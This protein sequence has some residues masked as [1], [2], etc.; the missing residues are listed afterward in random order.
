MSEFNYA[1][2][3]TSCGEKLSQTARFNRACVSEQIQNLRK[4]AFARKIPTADDESLQFLLTC[5]LSSNPQNILE[6]GTAVGISGAAMLSVLPN[7]KLVTI[8]RDKNFFEEAN[9]NFSDLNFSERVTQICGDAGEEIQKIEGEFDFILLDC[10]KVQYIKYLPRLKQLLKVGGT[11]YADD[12]LLYGWLTGEAEIP[13]KRK[14][15]ARHV[16]EYVQAVT[17]DSELLTTII[18]VGD[19]VALSVKKG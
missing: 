6:L 9:K 2:N 16:E 7:A 17:S 19:G 15:L 11:L 4:A 13:K 3:D 12:V 8:E 18:N 5:V 14:M 10:A 1:H